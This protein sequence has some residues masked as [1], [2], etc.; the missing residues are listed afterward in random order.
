M[1]PTLI[2]TNMQYLFEDADYLLTQE[3]FNALTEKHTRA[4]KLKDNNGAIYPA[5]TQSAVFWLDK[6]YLNQTPVNKKAF[7]DTL[8]C[9]SQINKPSRY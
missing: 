1:K 3:D 9:L 5:L 4:K 8:K 2:P 7:Q 6:A